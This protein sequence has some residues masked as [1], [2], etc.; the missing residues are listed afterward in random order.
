MYTFCINNTKL[1][2]F[3]LNLT[4]VRHGEVL[5][6]E[7]IQHQFHEFD[8]CVICVKNFENQIIELL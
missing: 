2:C 1:I 4:E 7:N 6:K 8:V 3:D 5:N